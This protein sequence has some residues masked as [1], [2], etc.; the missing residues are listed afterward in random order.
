MILARGIQ[1]PETSTTKEVYAPAAYLVLGTG[2]Y[3]ALGIGGS[4][5]DGDF[6]KDPFYALRVGVA[7]EVLPKLFLDINANYRFNEWEE[8]KTVDEDTNTDTITLGAAVRIE[9]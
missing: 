6:S 1:H 9:F 3:G 4:Y 5:S 7:I 2:L 8:I